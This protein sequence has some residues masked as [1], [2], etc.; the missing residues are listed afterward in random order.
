MATK[1]HRLLRKVYDHAHFTDL[2]GST[3]ACSN[4]SIAGQRDHLI[5]ASA[6]VHWHHQE[7]ECSHRE[8][9]A[10]SLHRQ[11]PHYDRS[12]SFGA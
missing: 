8:D 5:V 1:R 2:F 3:G 7:S 10:V 6:C 9:I 11:P 4:T 12:F